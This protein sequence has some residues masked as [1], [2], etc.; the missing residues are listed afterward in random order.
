VV[1]NLICVVVTGIY[2]PDS[3]SCFAGSDMFDLDEEGRT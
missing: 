2:I 3:C 1:D